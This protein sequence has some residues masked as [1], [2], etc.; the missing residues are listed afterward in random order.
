[1]LIVSAAVFSA[2]KKGDENEPQSTDAVTNASE[3]TPS[4]SEEPTSEEEPTE[5][6]V[7]ADI[8]IVKE[9]YYMFSDSK[10][11]VLI[12]KNNGGE[13]VKL[14]CYADA[15][16]AATGEV[17]ASDDE[18]IYAIGAGQTS[19]F[20]LYF[21]K[22]PEDSVISYKIEKSE[23]SKK[24]VLANLTASGDFQTGELQSS[25]SV[26]VTNNGEIPSFHTNALVLCYKEG[27]LV[28]DILLYFLDDDGELKPGETMTKDDVINAYEKRDFDD[29]EIYLSGESSYGY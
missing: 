27:K 5:P 26:E 23:T 28:N 20:K 10:D 29:I 16:D 9:D 24:D 22:A 3:N 8:E 2:C 6:P 14:K 15:K 19:Y 12:V 4:A 17:I 25:V 11:G 21:H 1:M 7:P 18:T 13:T